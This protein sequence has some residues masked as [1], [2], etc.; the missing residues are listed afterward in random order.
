MTR[1]HIKEKEFSLLRSL[2]DAGLRQA[3]VVKATGRSSCTISQI[4][5]VKTFAAYRQLLRETNVGSKPQ[6]KLSKDYARTEKVED[7]ETILAILRDIKDLMVAQNATLHQ[8][9]T[10]WESP[11]DYYKKLNMVR[12]NLS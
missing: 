12:S 11:A 10:L 9:E 2:L 1:K 6:V 4:A 8:L 5:K 7:S 3:A